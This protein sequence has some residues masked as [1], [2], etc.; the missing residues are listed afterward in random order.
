MVLKVRRTFGVQVKM[1]SLFYFRGTSGGR[2][3]HPFSRRFAFVG[4]DA[5]IAPPYTPYTHIGAFLPLPSGEV[6][7]P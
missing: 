1:A 2:P 5:Y 4:G 7:M 6:A 3:L